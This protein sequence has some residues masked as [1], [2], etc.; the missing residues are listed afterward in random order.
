MRKNLRQLLGSLLSAVIVIAFA[1]TCAYAA[2]AS[3]FTRLF[4]E[5]RYETMSR[6]I[7]T[8][9]PDHSDYAVLASGDNFPDALAASS[10]AGALHAPIILTSSS[11]LSDEARS[12]IQRLNVKT[13]A[14]VGGPF[15]VSAAVEHQVAQITSGGSVIRFFGNTRIE[16]ALAIYREAPLSLPVKWS[17]NA[18]I[19]TSS[20]FA[21]A[22]SISPYAFVSSSP[23]FLVDSA[24]GLNSGVQEAL[25]RESFDGGII[26]GGAVAVSQSIESQLLYHQLSVTRLSGDT[27]YNTSAEIGRFVLSSL[28]SNP[29]DVVFAT[30]ANFPD[31]LAGGVLAGVK[32]TALLLVE[33]KYSPTISFAEQNIPYVQNLYVLGGKSA[34]NSSTA[35]SISLRYGLGEVEPDPSE[36]VNVGGVTP[37]AFCKKI[38]SGKKALSKHGT[39]MICSADPGTNLYRWREYTGW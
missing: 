30:G 21:D 17:R 10:L 26:V 1:T 19:A 38:Y 16:T 32:N 20:N 15:A 12:E 33:N 9:F 39:V 29:N 27:R 36:Y 18:I 35:N 4:G 5:T 7:Q 8:A 6:I 37:G 23:I 24:A 11:T 3:S 22:L 2:S 25:S 13:V 31:A 14:I 28:N 34:V